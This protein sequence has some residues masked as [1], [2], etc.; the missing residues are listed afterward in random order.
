MSAGSISHQTMFGASA[1]LFHCYNTLSL[2]MHPGTFAVPLAW[3][4]A[5]LQAI[6]SVKPDITVAA[7]ALAI[8]HTCMYDAWA[9]YDLYA[10]GTYH[11]GTLRRPYIEHTQVNKEKA[12]SY[13]AYR[14]LIDL[15]PTQIGQFQTVLH[16][17]GYDPQRTVTNTITP[18]GIGNRVAQAIL[19]LRHHD[20]SNQMGDMATGAYSDYTG[21]H[22]QNTPDQLHDPAVWQPL[23]LSTQ[24]GTDIIQQFATPHWYRVQ[25]FALT[26]A[27]QHRPVGQLAVYPEKTY[28]RQAN[29]ILDYSARLTD[30]QKTMIE[31]WQNGPNQEQPAGHWCLIAQYLARRDSYNL[32]HTIKLFFLLANGLFD[33]SIACWDCKRAFDSVQPRTAIRYIFQGHDV[34]AWGGPYQGTQLIKG[35][36]WQPYQ[37]VDVVTPP[38]PEFCSEHSTLSATAATLLNWFSGSDYFGGSYTQKVGTSHIEPKRVPTTNITLTWKTFSSAAEQ[39]GLS[40]LYGGTNFPL[41]NQVGKELGNMVAAHIWQKCQFYITGHSQYI[42]H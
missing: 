27:S 4:N 35:D 2:L 21:Y 16:D 11:G 23:R 8:V 1:T 42:P 22:P 41:S 39:A 3:N 10:L 15:F 36:Y 14:A 32:D 34:Q 30:H 28:F 6:R 18:A 25:P 26:S 12:I 9:A 38:F 33:A 7:R 19:A 37:P 17:L 24:S 31:Y 5:T 29:D 20:G 40:R 13:A